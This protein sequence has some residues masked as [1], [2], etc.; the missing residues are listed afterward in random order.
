MAALLQRKRKRAGN[1]E[2]GEDE[3]EIGVEEGG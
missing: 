2:D 3:E 1:K